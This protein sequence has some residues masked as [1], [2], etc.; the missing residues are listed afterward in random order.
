MSH[1][2]SSIVDYVN[3]LRIKIIELQGTDSELS[4]RI[5]ELMNKFMRDVH[6]QAPETHLTEVNRFHIKLGHQMSI[7]IKDN[8]GHDTEFA[9]SLRKWIEQYF[10]DKI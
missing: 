4:K 7:W 9:I 10:K 6:Y 5:L 8:G 1:P 2:I 3:N